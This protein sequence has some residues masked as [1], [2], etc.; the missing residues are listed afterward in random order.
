MCTGQSRPSGRSRQLQP[1]VLPL[2]LLLCHL[3]LPLMRSLLHDHHHQKRMHES[4]GQSRRLHQHAQ[5]NASKA[6]TFVVMVARRSLV[7]LWCN[8]LF[9][10]ALVRQLE[11]QASAV[12]PFSV[13]KARTVRQ[14]ASIES[15]RKIAIRVLCGHRSLPMMMQILLVITTIATAMLRATANRTMQTAPVSLPPLLRLASRAAP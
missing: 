8:L 15:R 13:C 2:L 9:L 11:P 6:L 4:S 14:R 12:L 10:M 1:R 7:L 5:H 3:P